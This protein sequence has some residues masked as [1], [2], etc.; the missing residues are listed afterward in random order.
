MG[1]DP[2]TGTWQL[3]QVEGV[4]SD[5]FLVSGLLKLAVQEQS[6]DTSLGSLLP[7]CSVDLWIG[8]EPAQKGPEPPIA[9]APGLW[10][11]LIC[12]SPLALRVL[13]LCRPPV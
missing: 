11:L 12:Q 1:R 3:S 2:R 13:K 6:A 7:S 9:R 5:A 10:A 8:M 4:G